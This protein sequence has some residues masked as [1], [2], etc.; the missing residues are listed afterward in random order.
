MKKWAHTPDHQA[1]YLPTEKRSQ[2]RQYFRSGASA[3]LAAWQTGTPA[4]LVIAF[5]RQCK[6]PRHRERPGF[7]ARTLPHLSVSRQLAVRLK[8]AGLTYRE[9]AQKL[10]VTRQRAQQLVRPPL[11]T[12]MGVVNRSGGRCEECRKVLAKGDGHMHHI[13][14]KEW[15][16]NNECNLLYVCNS[17]HR[18]IHAREAA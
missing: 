14:I 4:W 17:C 5:Y 18:T 3:E 12:Y 7:H 10:G 11:P 2:L 8:V 15:D 6:P 9:I 1:R 13:S 16:Y